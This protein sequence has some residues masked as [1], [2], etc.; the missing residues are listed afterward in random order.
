MKEIT[1]QQLKVLIENKEEFQLIDVR[2]QSE[3]DKQDIGG[4]LLQMNRVPGN[5]DKINDDKPVIFYC[6]SG[7]R[8]AKV[9]NFVEMQKDNKQIY[10][11][12]GGILAWKKEIKD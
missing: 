1:P 9:A 3:K 4:E 2:E 5:L 7:V 10:S 11:L 12:K 6:K 8:S